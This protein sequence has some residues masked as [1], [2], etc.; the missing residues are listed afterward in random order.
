MEKIRICRVCDIDS[1]QIEF[2]PKANICLPCYRAE[3]RE[4][5]SKN[6]EKLYKQSRD[7]KIENHDKNRETERKLY[8]TPAGKAKHVA[9]TTK[10]PGVWLAK[11][12]TTAGSRSA[13]PGPHDPKGDS[14]KREH[15]IDP[16]YVCDI[17][18]Q[19]KGRCAITF[20]QMTFQIKNLTSA[21]IDRID[22]TKGH[23]KGN[24]QIVC[25]WVNYG[26]K[27]FPNSDMIKIVNDLVGP[28]PNCKLCAVME[29]CRDCHSCIPHCSC[30]F[31]IAKIVPKKMKQ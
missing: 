9:R 1:T 4:H 11:Q 6:R 28:R 2:R 5:H 18:N 10:T 24:I 7:W 29:Q 21:S 13:K 22:S 3:I 26:K 20:Q 12:V 17:W 23:I 14:P 25:Q 31:E 27:N 19:Q 15:N 16:Q 30:L 8:H